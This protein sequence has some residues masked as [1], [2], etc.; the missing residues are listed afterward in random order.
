MESAQN[1]SLLRKIRRVGGIAI[2]YAGI[3]YAGYRLG[4]ALSPARWFLYDDLWRGIA[5][6]VARVAR[7]A[8][9]YPRWARGELS[10]STP[11]ICLKNA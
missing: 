7:M 9:G 4:S 1:A 8:R 11:S 3:L 10:Q 5:L 6:D 2:T